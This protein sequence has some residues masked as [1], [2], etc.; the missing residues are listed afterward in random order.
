MNHQQRLAGGNLRSICDPPFRPITVGTEDLIEHQQRNLDAGNHS[1]FTGDQARR[2]RR[3]GRDCGQR[4]DVG[5]VAQV[6][7]ESPTD[8]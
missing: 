2:R 5:S 6:F 4:R 7:V 1:R 8:Q 3:I